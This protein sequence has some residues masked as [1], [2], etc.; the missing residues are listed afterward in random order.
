MSY[1][2]TEHY[3][4]ES[5]SQLF[6]SRKTRGLDTMANSLNRRGFNA[7]AGAT[8]LSQ[9]AWMRFAHANWIQTPKQIFGLMSGE[10]TSES[11]V[12]W[13][14]S[15][16][17]SRMLV[18]WDT[19]ASFTSPRSVMGPKVTQLTDFTGKTVLSDLPAGRRSTTA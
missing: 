14:R 12:V 11:A 9:S 16:V 6:A 8:L 13:G 19:A 2:P 7:T 15:D 5:D 1:N 18:Q 4:A 3:A 17:D 10:V